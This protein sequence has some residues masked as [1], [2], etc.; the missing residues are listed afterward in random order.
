MRH[1]EAQHFA[2]K[3][4][5]LIESQILPRDMQCTDEGRTVCIKMLLFLFRVPLILLLLQS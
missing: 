2:E 4:L 5:L 1:A 3:Y